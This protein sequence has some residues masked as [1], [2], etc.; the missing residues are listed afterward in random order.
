MKGDKYFIIITL[1][2][3]LMDSVI[4]CNKHG[5]NKDKYKGLCQSFNWGGST[6]VHFYSCCNNC[7]ENNGAPTCN[8]KTWHSASDGEYCGSCGANKGSGCRYN[9]YNS[10]WAK[11]TGHKGAFQ[12][13]GCDGQAKVDKQCLSWVINKPGFCWQYTSCFEEQC[14]WY[15]ATRQQTNAVRSSLSWL[16]SFMSE[17]SNNKEP[18]WNATFCGNLVCDSAMGETTKTCPLDCCQTVNSKCNPANATCNDSCC[19]KSSCCNSANAFGL[20]IWAMIIVVITSV[21]IIE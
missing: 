12:C 10:D 3:S 6:G 8:S 15:Y 13:G 4:A 17:S 21:I 16:P 5:I 14:G 11:W 7:N 9:G 1:Y 20:T 19:G 2:F 18:T